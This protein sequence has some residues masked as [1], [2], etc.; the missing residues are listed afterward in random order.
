MAACQ[1]SLFTRKIPIKVLNVCIFSHYEL[2]LCKTM[3]LSTNDNNNTRM[4]HSPYV[5]R[6]VF[7][8]LTCDFLFIFAQICYI[9]ISMPSLRV[10]H[11]IENNYSFYVYPVKLDFR[12][13]ENIYRTDTIPLVV[14]FLSKTT[15]QTLIFY[16]NF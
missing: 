12:I 8:L 15:W 10:F 16:S 3:K 4:F 2:C 11:Y 6:A 9:L 1:H 14:H 7:I 13:Y 5:S